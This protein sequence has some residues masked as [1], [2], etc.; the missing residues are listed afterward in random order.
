MLARTFLR[1]CALEAVRPSALLEQNGPWPTMAGAH[2]FDSRFDPIDDLDA[3]ERR[4]VI[5]IYTEDDHQEKIAQ[6]GPIYYK[7][8]TDLTFEIAVFTLGEEVPGGDF[9][10]GVPYTDAETEASLDALE[11]QI[12][13]ALHFGPSGHLFRKI[14]KVPA[15]NWQS[16]AMR[17][18]QEA[19]RLAA[20]TIRARF[21]V[22]E[23]CYQAVPDAP[24][25][26]LNRLPPA[27]KDIATALDGSTYLAKVIAGVAGAAPVMPTRVNLESVAATID[28]RTSS[29]PAD[30]DVEVEINSD[31]LQG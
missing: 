31:N 29:T 7:S 22:R 19:V 12:W 17:G 21:D 26:G 25:T 11:N 20:R 3:A 2:V 5:A 4:P 13:H 6:A 24:P 1:L 8:A 16:H 14:A 23:V 15:L 10:A 18:S 9:V 28:P 30:A 27:L